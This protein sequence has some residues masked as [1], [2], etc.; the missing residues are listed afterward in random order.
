MEITAHL[1]EEEMQPLFLILAVAGLAG[2]I[3]FI[4]IDAKKH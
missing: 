4:V 1:E 3:I 2:V